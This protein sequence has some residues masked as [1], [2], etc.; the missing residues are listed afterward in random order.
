MIY[1]QCRIQGLPDFRSRASSFLRWA[2]ALFRHRLD[3]SSEEESDTAAAMKSSFLI[4]A[5]VAAFLCGAMH[6]EASSS[7]QGAAPPSEAIT[8]AIPGP[9]RSF[10][11]MAGI[12]QKIAP[13]EVLPLL[14]RNVF[15]RG[16]EGLHAGH[17]TE[18]LI[19]LIRYVHQAREL[20]A[21][22]GPQG[23]IHVS[24]C[25]EAKPL[26]KVLGYLPR[27]DCGRTN[28]TLLTHDSERALLTIDSVFPLPDLAEGIRNRTSKTLS[29]SHVSA[30]WHL[31]AHNPAEAGNPR[32]SAE[33]W[34]PR[35]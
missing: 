7:Q 22:A 5:L 21:L 9:L 34:P 3:D 15:Q 16:Y 33:A 8:V 26:L 28:A 10:L 31:S 2:P 29:R 13:E 6:S 30:R 25:E 19:L 24:N 1:R 23:V 14:A 20:Q 35:N 32:L 27:P 18:F 12:S 4:S 11:R 17:Q